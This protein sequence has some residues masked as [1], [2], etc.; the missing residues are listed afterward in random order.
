MNASYSLRRLDALEANCLRQ[1]YVQTY[2]P[3]LADK[4]LCAMW[5]AAMYMGQM[6][7]LHLSKK[8]QHITFQRINKMQ[9]QFPLGLSKCNDLPF[10]QRI[11]LL[12]A[13]FWMKGICKI[14][15]ILKIGM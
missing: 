7:L 12:G 8:D 6:A 15:N 13:C 4:A 3:S 2:F 5:G 14:R 1:Q 10:T 11:W 9:K